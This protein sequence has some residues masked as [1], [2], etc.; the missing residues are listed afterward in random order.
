M[1]QLYMKYYCFEHRAC[2]FARPSLYF[3]FGEE[4]YQ[5]DYFKQKPRLFKVSTS[6]NNCRVVLPSGRTSTRNVTIEYEVVHANQFKYI[7]I[8]FIIHY[9]GYINKQWFNFRNTLLIS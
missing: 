8:V 6:L 7:N 9:D 1:I 5:L 4:E 3:T 2:I